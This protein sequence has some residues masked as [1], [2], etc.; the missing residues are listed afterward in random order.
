MPCQLGSK[1]LNALGQLGLTKLGK[2]QN[3]FAAP[4]CLH[5]IGRGAVHRQTTGSGRLFHS[6]IS[7]CSP[8][9]ANHH[10]KAGSL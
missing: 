10:F 8:F 4:V 7:E 6:L 5:I 1:R 2:R 9:E 3:E